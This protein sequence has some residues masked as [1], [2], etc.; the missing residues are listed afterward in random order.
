MAETT[1]GNDARTEGFTCQKHMFLIPVYLETWKTL[2]E[3]PTI[4]SLAGISKESEA[5]DREPPIC[6]LPT[7][8]TRPGHFQHS[9]VLQVPF[10][11]HQSEYQANAFERWECNTV[12]YTKWR[13][14]FDEAQAIHNRPGMFKC[15]FPIFSIGM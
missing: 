9:W 3:T 7:C 5:F 10:Y 14:L 2:S 11:Q 1:L 8:S 6:S 4:F 15:F 13:F 12:S